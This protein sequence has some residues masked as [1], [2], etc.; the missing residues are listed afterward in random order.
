MAEN[1][2]NSPLDSASLDERIILALEI[3]PD[4]Q[5]PGDFAARVAG[6]VVPRPSAT[7]TPKRYGRN[8][9]IVCLG[10]LFVLILAYAHRA[11]ASVLWTPIESMTESM[12]ESIFCIQFALLAA[13]LVARKTGRSSR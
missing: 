10:V 6:Q 13:W 11:G 5:I 4:P 9:A 7:L 3:A 8:T 12:I 1:S 2:M